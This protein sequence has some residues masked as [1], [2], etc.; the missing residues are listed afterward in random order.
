MSARGPLAPLVPAETLGS[1]VVGTSASWKVYPRAGAGLE[2]GARALPS[3]PAPASGEL[4]LGQRAGLQGPSHRGRKG[5][6][7][8]V[9][10]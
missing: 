4:G 10:G 7:G 1:Q 9:L 6:R 2:P 5:V 3:E 8:A